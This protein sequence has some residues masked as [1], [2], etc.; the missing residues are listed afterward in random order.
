MSIHQKNFSL[1]DF[2]KKKASKIQ[3]YGNETL[4][5]DG[6]I[7]PFID[8]AAYITHYLQLKDSDVSIPYAAKA[9]G[10]FNLWSDFV[11]EEKE[12]KTPDNVSESNVEMQQYLF[13]DLYTAP[14]QAQERPTFK[15]IDLF[16]GIG[17][18]RMAFQNFT[19]EC[20]F[21]WDF[22]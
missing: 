15:F 13:P 19:V 4:D 20:E 18:F 14:F 1:F 11:R 2:C 9:Q 16:A 22:S 10:I 21:S 12:Y 5:E 6:N 17:G 3:I 7:I 8:Q